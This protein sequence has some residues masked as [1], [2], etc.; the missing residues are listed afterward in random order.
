MSDGRA[1]RRLPYFVSILLLR[2][3]PF[4]E[5]SWKRRACRV[6][7]L[8]TYGYLAIVVVMLSLED[9]L[10]YLP[11]SAAEWASP[12]SGLPIQD[13]ELTGRDGNRVHAWWSAPTGWGP[14]QGAVL[15]CHGNGGNLSHRGWALHSWHKEMRMAVLLFDY[16]GFGR[17]EGKPSEAGCYAAADTAYDWLVKSQK[18]PPERIVLYGGS[19]GGG[20]ATDLATRRPHRALVLVSAFTSFPDMAQQQYPW[21]PGRWLVHNQ[22]D[23]LGKIAA[24]RG[25]VFLAHGR[26]DHLIPLRHAEHLFAAAGE[27]KQL[28]IMANYSH[29]DAPNDDVFPVLRRFLDEHAP[30]APSPAAN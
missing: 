21:L 23:N 15:F 11:G 16:P 26:D 3:V 12:P 10:L 17:S 30:L 22:F 14:S 5:R 27:P 25:P 19:L 13:V 4:W 29:N 20:V 7:A 1:P 24:C 2:R 6:V 9:R 28:V 8:C 18:V